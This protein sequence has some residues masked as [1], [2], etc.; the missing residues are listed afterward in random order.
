[1][2]LVPSRALGSVLTW[3]IW[4]GGVASDGSGERL[5]H[6][7]N[8]AGVDAALMNGSVNVEKQMSKHVFHLLFVL[9]F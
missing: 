6:P 3:P 8:S 1:M 5:L 4:M 9:I 7:G 2:S